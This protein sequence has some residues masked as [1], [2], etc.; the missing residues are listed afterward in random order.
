M[1]IKQERVLTMIKS[2]FRKDLANRGYMLLEPNRRQNL[3]ITSSSSKG[4]VL[5]YTKVL[6][7]QST[8]FEKSKIIF[9]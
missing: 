4:L 3:F 8:S 5:K 2:S 1:N 6:L 7:N 9:I